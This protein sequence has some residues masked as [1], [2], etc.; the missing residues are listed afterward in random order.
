MTAHDSHAADSLFVWQAAEEINDAAVLA[1]NAAEVAAE[2]AIKVAG[3]TLAAGAAA[4]QAALAYDAIRECHAAMTALRDSIHNAGT[5]GES[6]AV[7]ADWSALQSAGDRCR[8][9]GNCASDSAVVTHEAAK[10]LRQA[11]VITGPRDGVYDR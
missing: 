11:A 3:A 5:V 6:V 1:A 4:R 8:D 10:V 7:G 9:R 2:V